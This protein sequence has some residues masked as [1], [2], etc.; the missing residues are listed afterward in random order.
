MLIWV[1]SQGTSTQGR[2]AES[3]HGH[4]GGSGLG[5]AC[6]WSPLCRK[7][8]SCELAPS[9]GFAG[10]DVTASPS[11][12][13]VLCLCKRMLPRTPTLSLLLRFIHEPPSAP[14]PCGAGK[15]KT[16]SLAFCAAGFV[17]TGANQS[18]WQ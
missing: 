10:A 2:V 16:L 14:H 17:P 15:E 9:L 4:F 18:Y 11:L 7:I 3:G 13:S 1:S 12:I 5:T 6:E 8:E